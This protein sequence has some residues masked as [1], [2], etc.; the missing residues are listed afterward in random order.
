MKYEKP[1]VVVSTAA[2]KAIEAGGLKPVSNI[3]D[4]P[5]SRPT[6]A[7]YEADE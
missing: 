7:A 4:S 1:E 6:N 5:D 2:L 3:N